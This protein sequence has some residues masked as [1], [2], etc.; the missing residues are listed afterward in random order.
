MSEQT[1]YYNTNP[2]R[3]MSDEREYTRQSANLWHATPP[4]ADTPKGIDAECAHIWGP[5]G[6][7]V[8]EV[9]PNL[10]LD[11]SAYER[12][13][14]I[15][16]AHNLGHDGSTYHFLADRTL[17][18]ARERGILSEGTLPAQSTKM[19]EE[20]IETW[21]AINGLGQEAIEELLEHAE[22]L[23][24][25]GDDDLLSPLDVEDGFGDMQVTLILTMHMY[26]RAIERSHKDTAECM[27]IC[28]NEVL[29]VIEQRSGAMQNGAFVK[30]NDLDA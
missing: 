25:R 12:A 20:C 7:L 5:D 2:K 17:Q 24:A 1:I 23:S 18:W 30:E 22:I 10:V 9:H 4:D 28:W 26:L 14:S 8:A 15:V 3:T 21:C 29:E 11:E 13:Q 16:R 19:L 27:L 6:D